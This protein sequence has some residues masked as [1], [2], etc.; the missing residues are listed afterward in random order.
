MS[1]SWPVLVRI[2]LI[3]TVAAFGLGL[4]LNSETTLKP[5][6]KVPGASVKL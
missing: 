3:K 1:A 6:V 4:F 5:P 2:Q